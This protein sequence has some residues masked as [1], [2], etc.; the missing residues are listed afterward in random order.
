MNFLSKTILLLSAVFLTS[1]NFTENLDIKN[2]GTGTFSVELDGSGLMAM[3]GDKMGQKIGQDSKKTAID[4]TFSFKELLKEKKDSIAKLP[5]K[6]QEAL[7]K[8]ENFVMHM[9]MDAVKK[10]FL[11]SINTPFQKI[12]DLE[13]VMASLKTLKKLKGSSNEDQLAMPLGD[14]FGDN[15]SKLSFAYSGSNFSRTAQL[16]PKKEHN[17]AEADSLGMLKMIF[18]GSNYTLKYHFP[19]RVKTVSNP[20]AMFSADKK[21]ITV[22]YPFLDYMDSP[23]KLN[24]KVEFE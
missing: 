19:K 8:I 21:T 20:N 2:D 9:K 3:A 18:A 17:K 5:A 4:S 12:S 1:C 22:E 11:F 10:Q 6:D 16:L 14:D 7:K 24:L 15:N 23:D 13:N